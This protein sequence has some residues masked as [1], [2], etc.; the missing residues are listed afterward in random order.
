MLWQGDAQEAPQEL[1]QEPTQKAV[2]PNADEPPAHDQI[3]KEAEEDKN[4]D[5]VNI[6]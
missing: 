1:K 6:S 2:E 5:K 3:E 4:K